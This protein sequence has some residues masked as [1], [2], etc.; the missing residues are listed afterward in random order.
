M[1]TRLLTLFVFYFLCLSCANAEE[2]KSGNDEEG[3]RFVIIDQS[4]PAYI[5]FT[6]IGKNTEENKL[7]EIRSKVSERENVSMITWE[8]FTASVGKYAQSLMKT[9]DYPNY[10]VSKGLMCLVWK[11]P[12]WHWGL[13]WNGGIA[14]TFNDYRYAK[15]RYESYI[16]NPD[17]Y[18]PMRDPRADPINPGGFL[19]AFGCLVAEPLHQPE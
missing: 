2:N 12:R 9:N 6:G 17:S 19:P 11:R 4:D 14:L 3:S 15:Q 1:R 16:A 10:Q 13:T 7:T 18:S 8:K 5:V